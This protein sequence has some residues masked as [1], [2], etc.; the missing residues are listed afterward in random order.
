MLVDGWPRTRRGKRPGI[1]FTLDEEG[2]GSGSQWTLRKTERFAG[3]YA[4]IKDKDTYTVT[5]VSL[6]VEP[7]SLRIKKNAKK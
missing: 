5:Y 3:L 1:A 6:D 7:I 2:R 4:S